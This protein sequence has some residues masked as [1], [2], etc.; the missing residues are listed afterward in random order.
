MVGAFHQ[1]G[2][3]PA[4]TKGMDTSRYFTET[5]IAKPHNSTY[6]G[7]YVGHER[8]RLMHKRYNWAYDEY[9]KRSDFSDI[10]LVDIKGNVVYS[11]YNP[12]DK[13]SIN[14]LADDTPFPALQQT[15]VTIKDKTQQQQSE[16][17][18][19]PV[20]FT[21][22][23]AAPSGKEN[24]AWFAAPPIIQQGYL[25]SYVF[26]KLGNRSISEFIADTS[27]NSNHVQTLLVGSDHLSPPAKWRYATTRSLEPEH[28]GSPERPKRGSAV[29]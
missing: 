9:L 24:A 11:A 25:H 10:L 4:L 17:E 23:T 28:R 6:S 13:F 16:P 15:F 7:N 18:Q 29:S 22:F 5:L 12:P 1:L 19:V 2:D 26:F 8:Y 14:L 27:S 20:A 21:D 3:I